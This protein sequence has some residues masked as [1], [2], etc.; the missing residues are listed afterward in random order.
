M[1]CLNIAPSQWL[2]GGFCPAPS[3]QESNTLQAAS[4]LTRLGT[5]VDSLSGEARTDME[6]EVYVEMRYMS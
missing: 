5:L 3:G 4:Q 2:C 6:D 1:P